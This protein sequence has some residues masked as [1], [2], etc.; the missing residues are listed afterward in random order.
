MFHDDLFHFS[1]GES[2]SGCVDDIVF[3][4]HDVEVTV[5]I[6]ETGVSG[7]VVSGYGAEVLLNVFIVVV[8][9][10]VHE[11]GGQGLFDVD[12]TDLVGLAG[13]A[14]GGVD[15]LDVVAGEGFAG[16]SWF[17]REGFEAEVVGE[18]GSACFGLPVAVVDQFVFEV[19][20]HPL[21]GRYVTA[22]S[23]QGHASQSVEVVLA[24]VLAL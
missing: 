10:G 19:L 8:E 18:D 16:G 17:L 13:C 23:D 7:V 3:S 12:G 15:D 24:D 6:L 5:L 2:V 22:L 9:D 1:C 14:G 4:G 20:L 21:E 11:G